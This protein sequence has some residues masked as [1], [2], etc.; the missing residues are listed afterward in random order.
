[1]PVRFPVLMPNG[2]VQQQDCLTVGELA[3]LVLTTR[4]AVY[5]RTSAD[6]W[7]HI[8]VVRRIYFTPEHVR[9]ILAMSEH[10]PGGMDSQQ[11]AP[12]RHNVRKLGQG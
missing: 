9:T 10:R 2:T 6:E 11:S 3:A 4:D 7:P 1:M 5:K 12:T 8:K